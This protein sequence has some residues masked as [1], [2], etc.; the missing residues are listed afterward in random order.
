M[1]FAV[2]FPLSSH[3]ESP[4]LAF[5]DWLRNQLPTHVSSPPKHSLSVATGRADRLP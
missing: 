2:S 1:P 4:A 3:L 5:N